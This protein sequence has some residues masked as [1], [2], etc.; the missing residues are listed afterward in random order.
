MV[1]LVVKNMIQNTKSKVKEKDLW[2]KS[3]VREKNQ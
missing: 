2:I 1:F 3:K